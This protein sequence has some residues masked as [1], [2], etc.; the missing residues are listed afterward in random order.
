ML[1]GHIEKKL[2]LS[3]RDIM[4][5]E[6]CLQEIQRMSR[7]FFVRRAEMKNGLKRINQRSRSL[8]DLSQV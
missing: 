5:Q 4:M 2:I 3:P 8:G 6:Q 1:K 7:A